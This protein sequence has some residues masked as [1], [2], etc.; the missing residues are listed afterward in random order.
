MVFMAGDV[1]VK[2]PGAVSYYKSFDAETATES[3]KLT[4]TPTF[5]NTLLEDLAY[6]NITK[7]INIFG[8]VTEEDLTGLSFKLEK[9][10]E[11]IDTYVLGED[12]EKVDDVWQLKNPI[13]VAPGEGYTVTEILTTLEGYEVSVKHMVGEAPALSDG[14]ETD[15]F[16]T[17]KDETTNVSFYNK[18]VE[19][20]EAAVKKIWVDSDNKD[21]IRPA[22][23][24]MTLS[25]GDEVTLNEANGWAGKV[26]NLPKYNANGVEITY[27]WTEEVVQGYDQSSSKDGT[28]TTFTNIHTPDS[29]KILLTKTIKG[30]VT[31]EEAEGALQFVVKKGDQYVKADGSLSN[32]EEILTLADFSHDEGSDL[33][34]LELS[35]EPGSYT[36][37]ETV[38]NING[39]KLVSQSYKIDNGQAVQNAKKTDAFN[40]ENK[41]TVTVA[42]TDEYSNKGDLI[43]TKTIEGD[44]SKKEAEGALTFT[45]KDSENNETTYTLSQFEYNDKTKTFTLLLPK[46][47]KGVYTVTENVTDVTGKNLVSHTYKIG[48]DVSDEFTANAEVKAGESTT[49]AYTNKYEEKPVKLV[50]TKTISGD[51]TEEEAKGGITFT[52]TGPDNY[53]LEN[54]TLEN[55]FIKNEETGKYVLELDGLKAGEYT[56]VESLTAPDGR[57]YTVRNTINNGDVNESKT[58]TADI[59]PGE[60]A[61]ID[62]ENIYTNQPVKLVLTKT[63]KGDVTEDEA[64]GGIVFTILGP[65]DYRRVAKINDDFT[66]DQTSGKYVLEIDGLAAGEYTVVET[67][68]APDGRT[69]TVT[70]TVN[71][72]DANESETATVD[73]AAGTTATID[74]ENVY[75]ETRGDLI[76]KKTIQGD[77]TKEEAKGA[78]KFNVKSSDGSFDETYTL[79]NGFEY[80]EKT[81]TFTKVLPKLAQGDYTVTE[82]VTDI[83]GKDYTVTYKVGEEETSHEGKEASATVEAKKSTTVAYTDV[84]TDQPVKIILT[85]TI[86]GDVTKEEAEG[87]LTFAITG[88]EGIVK[89]A[90]GKEVFTLADF[91]SYDETN[92]KYTLTLEGLKAGEYTVVE[93]IVAP[94]GRVV[95]V[96]NTVNGT[97]NN[98]DTA[99]VDINAGTTANIDYEND[100]VETRGVLIIKKTIKGTLTKAE[101]DGALT[102]NVKS[103]DGSFDETYNV[104]DHFSYNKKTKTYTKVL[105]N[106][107]EGD[108][109][110]T[111]VITDIDGKKLVSVT[112]KIGDED[113]VEGKTA[114]V[115]VDANGNTTVA[116]EDNYR[117]IQGDLIITKTL[118]GPVT[119]EEAKGA[120]VFE[121]KN[122]DESYKE[123][124]KLSQFEYIAK[125]DIYT[126]ALTGLKPGAYTVTETDY[127]I[128]G[129]ELAKVSYK[130]TAGDTESDAVEGKSADVTVEDM[131]SVNLAFED[132]YEELPVKIVLTKTIKGDVTKEEA[133]GSLTFA[134]TGPEGVVKTAKG[135]EVFT[136]ADFDSYDETTNKYTLTLEGLKAGEYTVVESI[137]APDGRVVTVTNTVNGTENNSDTATASINAGE[138]ANIDYENNYVETRGTLVI[139]KTIKGDLTPEE[140]AGSLV[141]NVRKSTEETGTDYTVATDFS[142]DSETGKYTLVLDK[143][144]EGEYIITETITGIDGME[145]ISVTHKVGD[146]EAEEGKETTVNIS[147]TSGVN[148]E[149]EDTY[150]EIKGSILLTKT[151]EGELT[152]E[153]AKGGIT[154]TITGPDNYSR[155]ATIV[156]DF[157]YNDELGRFELELTDLKLGT[158]TVTETLVTP[159]G[160]I[161]SV[162]NKINNGA[163]NQGAEAEV[164]LTGKDAVNVDYTNDYTDTRG[165]LVITKTIKGDVTKEEAEGALSFNVKNSD[166]SFDETYTL[167]ADF[168][169]DEATKTFT[170]KLVNLAEDTYTVTEVIVDIE[171]KELTSV[172]YKAGEA[173]AVEGQEATVNLDANGAVLAYENVYRETRG[174]LIITKTISGDVTKEEAEGAL[175]FTVKSSDGSFEETYTLLN[176]FEYDEQTKTFTKV[177]QKLDEGTYT[178]TENITDITGKDLISVTYQVGDADAVEG[179]VATADVVGK[180]STTVAYEDVYKAQTGNLE[181]TKTLSGDVTPEEEQGGLSFS[182]QN[183]EGK[184]LDKDGNEN[185]EPVT[186]T[187]AADF[188]K[189]DDGSYTLKFENVPVGEYKVSE[190]NS[191]IEGF[192]ESVSYSINNEDSVSAKPENVAVSVVKDETAKIVID[193]AYDKLSSLT[194]HVTEEHSGKDVPG[195]VIKITIPDN[196]DVPEEYV[197]DEEGKV[198]I[199][200]LPEGDYEI[201]VIEVPED[202]DVRTG[203]KETVPV[204]KDLPGEHEAVIGTDM[205]ALKITVLDE[206]TGGPVP[207]AEVKITKPD[208]S[209]DIKYTDEN[210]EINDYLVKDEFDNYTL[211]PGTYTTEVTKIPEGYKV[212]VGEVITKDVEAAKDETYQ[213]TEYIAKI[214]PKTGGLEIYV[215][216]ELSKEPVPHAK[217]LVELPDGTSVTLETDDNGRIGTFAEK[218]LDDD[219]IALPGD[220]KITVL[221]VPEDYFVTVGSTKTKTVVVD[222]L[223]VHIAEINLKTGGLDIQVVD[224][225]TG[226]PVP[227]AIV[228]ILLPDGSTEE[229]TT[230]DDGM[231]L[232]YLET[233]EYGRYK[234]KPGDY[235]ITVIKVPEGYSVTTGKTEKVTV[236][237]GEVAHHIAKIAKNEDKKSETTDKTSFTGDD[238]HILVLAM[239]AV[240]AAAGFVM[241]RKREEEE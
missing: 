218:D 8:E 100:Y 31:E 195:A 102:F 18:Y 66:F 164:T 192:T 157:T 94:D 118:S 58:A 138:T 227:K 103:S 20:T 83:E 233:D 84:Y 107:P 40:V 220:Y 5:E 125:D 24:K 180:G 57:N 55:N 12:F 122:S 64:K 231:I 15:S 205:G 141:F 29:G 13:P 224:E 142:Y 97:E 191:S 179:N 171:G 99:T 194:V 22:S 117:N 43:I 93:T 67:V 168:E 175:T 16:E 176:D 132:V 79:L 2:I 228:K 208:G 217:V 70:N 7:S 206:K 182:V 173:D 96:K 223:A 126:L 56:V 215:Q 111:E 113:A 87:S 190:I 150:K 139:T 232:K 165:A 61:T 156:D 4:V 32:Q 110:V 49:V 131:K 123:T 21:G 124:F 162:T 148:V 48:N 211:K 169:Y 133:E 140:A 81:K 145:L 114:A 37:E 134:I 144:D 3:D 74:Y 198:I 234:S 45:V 189:N 82:I 27:T 47:T 214:K 89:T 187:L 33:Y 35:V 213:P 229:L 128:T 11:E 170:K 78:L 202:Y 46:L 72:G 116:Y 137:V 115:T 188:V 104:K 34:T 236:V 193:N 108:Y 146:N 92:N 23:I 153:E 204:R 101:A 178:V 219:Y 14:E 105:T 177:L 207:N 38:Y 75:V 221:E 41:K 203:E 80:D 166:G 19:L 160:F 36:V 54:L 30:N 52:I 17:V 226:K 209:T 186:L 51:V 59:A 76:I 183:S 69:Y 63:I 50:V 28:V 201:E 197:T 200:N 225:K 161:V 44:I 42:Y 10:G 127:D 135:A 199:K 1:E 174:D 238:T 112:H 129:K 181:I 119:D 121:V 90:Q 184:Y 240:L 241:L 239:L 136:L 25:N 73:I 222:E 88:P 9:D 230:D 106:L 98:S 91:D 152:E 53:K 212:T 77:I 237:V 216:D 196:P 235:E 95:S 158:Y 39:L 149:Y 6:I 120:L 26:S 86:K 167:L 172:S 159:E 155:T 85:K 185:E 65:D 71:G 60:T 151:I 154:F 68:T 163:V 62:Y 147:S 130:I 210:G 143:L 109:T